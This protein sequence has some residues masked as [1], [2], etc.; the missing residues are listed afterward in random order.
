MS[1]TPRNH[2]LDR[3]TEVARTILQLSDNNPPLE[4]Y[5]VLPNNPQGQQIQRTEINMNNGLPFDQ[6]LHQ[7]TFEGMIDVQ[8]QPAM[9]HDTNQFT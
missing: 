6:S 5:S 8:Q 9:M 4:S 7:G 3:D 1:S 2:E